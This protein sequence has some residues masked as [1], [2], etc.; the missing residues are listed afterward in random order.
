MITLIND[1]RIT[2]GKK[3]VGYLNPII[4][5]PLFASAFND[6]TIGSNQGCGTPGFSTAR[7]WD[8]VTGLGTP[9]FEK[10]LAL[11]LVLP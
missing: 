4:Y 1:A 3:S 8:P 9:N 6:I 2:I 11:F 5:T 7:G 10:L